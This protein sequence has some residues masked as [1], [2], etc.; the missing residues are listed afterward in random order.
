MAVVIVCIIAGLLAGAGVGLVGISSAT[1][2]TPM[3]I[4]ILKM[5]AYKA[6]GVALTAD[7]LAAG[8][9]SYTYFKHKN[10]DIKNGI[11]IM[12]TTMIF[13]LLSSFLSKYIPNG[14]LGGFSIITTGLLGLKFLFKPVKSKE[15]VK[16]QEISKEKKF[17]KAVLSGAV[18]GIICG[19]IGAGGGLMLLLMLT[20][21][22]GYDLKTAIGT[23]T[24][25]MAFTAL[26][27]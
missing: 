22:L 17:I 27:G 23:S 10:I 26:T 16:M 2:I 4:V 5:N 13:T 25:I 21:V 20:S 19:V 9:S 7:V 18:I 12:I 3:L 24:F 6:I 1:V 8:V 15:E 14:A 11:V